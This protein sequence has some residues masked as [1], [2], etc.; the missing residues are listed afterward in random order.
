MKNRKGFTLVELL[1]VI[2]ILGVLL[3]IAVPAVQNIINNSKQKSF[4][5]EAELILE[6]VETVVGTE[7]LDGTL[8]AAGCYVNISSVQLERGQKGNGYVE[9]EGTTGKGTIYYSD[10]GF[11]VSAT[12]ANI[13]SATL[14]SSNYGDYSGSLAAC[15]GF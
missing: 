6:N 3:L 9:V 11:S 2:V 4:R 5:R 14:G 13:K 12:L 10:D 8:P 1:A 15:P 7:K